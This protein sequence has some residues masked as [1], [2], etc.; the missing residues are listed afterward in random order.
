[1]TY[2]CRE[3]GSDSSHVLILNKLLKTIDAH[4]CQYA[5][6]AVSKYATSTREKAPLAGPLSESRVGSGKPIQLSFGDSEALINSTPP[7]R[8]SRELESPHELPLYPAAHRIAR[9]TTHCS[10]FLDRQPLLIRIHTLSPSLNSS[11]LAGRL[12]KSRPFI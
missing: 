5:A 4:A 9:Y 12:E 2:W 10:D 1:M 11:S 7:V 3:G 6:N 8:P